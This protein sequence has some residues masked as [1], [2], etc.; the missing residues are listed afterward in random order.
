MGKEIIYQDNPL[1]GIRVTFHKTPS[2][3]DI[4]EKI[5]LALENGGLPALATKFSE[6]SK[7]KGYIDV[8]AIASQFVEIS[9]NLSGRKTLCS[10]KLWWSELKKEEDNRNLS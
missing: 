4:K 6:D 7:K 2:V 5:I 8:I 9:I 10:G 1:T 3:N